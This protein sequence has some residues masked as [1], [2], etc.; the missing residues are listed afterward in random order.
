M[1]PTQ[2]LIFVFADHFEPETVGKLEVWHKRY[3]HMANKF[4]DADGCHPRHTWFYCGEDPWALDRLGLLAK[5][6]FGEVELHVH[7]SYDTAG[8][9]T[10]K[11][12]AL[13]TLYG[14]HGALITVDDPP[15]RAYGFTHGKWSLCNSRGAK[16]C[17]VNGELAV[18][19]KTG[20]YA[21]FTFPAW[22]RMNPRKSASIYYAANNF[23]YPKAYNTGVDV[24]VGGTPSGHL[25]IFMGPGDISGIPAGIARYRLLRYILW[26][27]RLTTDITDFAPATPERV[28]AWVRRRVHVKGRAEWTFVKVQTHGAREHAFDACFGKGAEALHS[29]LTQKYNDGQAWR[30]H[31]ATAR[32]AYNMVK[33]AERGMAGDPG[34]YRDFAIS[35]YQNT[36]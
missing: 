16:H 2:H 9:L 6:G 20:C 27:C 17:G 36:R 28:D 23:D 4:T 22:G 18:L 3:P 34:Q 24:E 13:K 29:Y 1:G 14:R 31:Y 5:G 32:E 10:R 8:F 19:K 12:G 26:C 21:D 7:H 35:P 15:K 33:A 11:I 30:L 25:M